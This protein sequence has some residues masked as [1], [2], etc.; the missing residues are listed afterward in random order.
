MDKP[1]RPFRDNRE[2]LIRR[3][4]ENNSLTLVL[5]AFIEVCHAKAKERDDNEEPEQATLWRKV[6][7]HLT[8]AAAIVRGVDVGNGHQGPENGAPSDR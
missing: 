2:K 5:Q 4:I 6:C 3:F 7:A 8:E 1:D